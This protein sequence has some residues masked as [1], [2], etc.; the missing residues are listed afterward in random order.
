MTSRLLRQPGWER[1][2]V[3]WAS[4]SA[5]QPFEWG[6]TDCAQLA[7]NAIRA[8]TIPDEWQPLADVRHY[9][10]RLGALRAA[11]QSGG[12]KAHL[13]RLGLREVRLRYLQQGDIVVVPASKG[14]ALEEA[15]VWVS[16]RL[17]T[18][19]EGHGVYWAGRPV[20]DSPAIAMRV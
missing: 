2:L 13:A 4:Y 10:T 5:G 15:S 16:G 3:Q 8:M 20:T 7:L 6:V 11:K 17:L 18:A 14:N 1:R 9:A 19:V 12:I